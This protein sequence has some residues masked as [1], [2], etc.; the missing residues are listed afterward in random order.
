MADSS[1]RTLSVISRRRWT[2]SSPVRARISATIGGKV[3]VGD[4]AGGEVDGDVEGAGVGPLLVPVDRL[5]AGALLD[6]APDRLDQ[7]AVLGDRDEVAG[8]EQAALRVLPADQRL[9]AGDLAGAQADHRLVVEGR[10]RRGRARGAA[11]VRPRAGA[12]P[13]PASRHRR[14]RSGRDRSPSPGTSPRRRRG[15][16]AR[17]RSDSG[18]STLATAMPMLAVTK[19]STPSIEKGWAKAAATRSAIASASLFVGEA[20]DQDPELVAAEAGDD[21]ARTQVRAAGAGQPPAAAR[22]RRDGRGCR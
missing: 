22:R 21:V 6:P 9:E 19:C 10:A 11:R 14:A 3:A 7:A 18:P 5:A 8:F 1:T 17:R 16:A 4:L 12:S 15:S 20:V 13:R 2:G